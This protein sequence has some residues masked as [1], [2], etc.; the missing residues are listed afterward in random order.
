MGAWGKADRQAQTRHHLAHHSADVAAVLIS[1]MDIPAFR[2]R[3]DAA[4]GRP[5][6]RAE[7]GCLG[8]LAFLH[9]IG[10]LATGFQVKAWD[11][12]PGITPRGHVQCGWVW[13]GQG[14][15]S[16]ALGGHAGLLANWPDIML[17]FQVLFAHHGRPRPCRQKTGAAM[18]STRRRVMT[19]KPRSA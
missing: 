13:L 9:D 2:D 18:R 7:I 17:W 12:N 8:A 3:A 11:R 15:A 6:S 4:I 10:K 19:G 1:L 14:E 5:I 16:E